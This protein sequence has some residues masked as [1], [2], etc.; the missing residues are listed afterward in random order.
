MD[1]TQPSRAV[2]KASWLEV[3]HPKGSIRQPCRAHAV[4]EGAGFLA[5]GASRQDDDVSSAALDHPVTDGFADATETA[6]GEV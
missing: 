5:I 2:R 3:S 6:D 1:F 4:D